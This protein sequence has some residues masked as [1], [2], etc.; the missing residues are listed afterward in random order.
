LKERFDAFWK[1]YPKKAAKEAAWKAWEKR[2]PS[3]ELTRQ[4]CAALA[5]QRQQDSWLQAGG[6]YIPHP[7]TWLTDGRWQD[8]PT[9]MPRLSDRTLAL[10]RTNE[11]FVRGH[12]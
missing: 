8:E 6:K 7:A 2:R 11:Q 4:M 3:L 9:N 12:D 5:W 10:G 1:A